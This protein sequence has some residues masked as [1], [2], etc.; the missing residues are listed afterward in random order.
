MEALTQ[1]HAAVVMDPAASAVRC[2]PARPVTARWTLGA[3]AFLLLLV[4]A[5]YASAADTAQASQSLI[6]CQE[7]SNYSQNDS[8]WDAVREHFPWGRRAASTELVSIRFTPA[9]WV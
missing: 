8:K 3:A 5:S 2:E 9:F 6:P 1:Y 7:A 4:G